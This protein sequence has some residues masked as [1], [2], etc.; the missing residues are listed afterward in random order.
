MEEE[1]ARWPPGR[2][3]RMRQHHVGLS[4]LDLACLTRILPLGKISKEY[5]ARGGDYEND[6]ESKNKP[7]KGQPEPKSAE[8]KPVIFVPFHFEKA[9][10]VGQKCLMLP[11][12]LQTRRKT[13]RQPPTSE[14]RMTRLRRR[15]RT[16]R[17]KERR[18]TRSLPRS[19]PRARRSRSPR[20]IKTQRRNQRPRRNL[21]AK[22]RRS[23]PARQSLLQTSLPL[24]PSLERSERPIGPGFHEIYNHA[25]ACSP[26]HVQIHRLFQLDL[27]IILM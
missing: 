24:E 20:K 17:T 13:A 11:V 21:P 8:G 12:L 10:T 26:G 18:Q 19:Q 27:I 9:S 2:Q 23:Q 15:N 6:P 5:E 14:R 7:K 16:A 22:P 4:E 1:R 3:A 25:L